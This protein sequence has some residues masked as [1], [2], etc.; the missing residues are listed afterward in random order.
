MDETKPDKR[1]RVYCF[2]D[3]FNLYHAIQWFADGVDDE[4]KRQYRQY[5]WLSLISLAKCYVSSQSQELV[6]VELFTTVTHWDQ[7]KALRHKQF[8]MAQECE[9]VKIT[10][11]HFKE[12]QMLCKATCRAV[13]SDWQEKQTDVNIAVRMVE[14]AHAEAYDKAIIISGD[15]DLIP[16][17][18]LV[19][20]VYKRHVAAVV[21]IGRRGEDIESACDSKF[22]MTEDHLSRSHLPNKLRHPSGQWVLKPYEYA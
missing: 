20:T 21:P 9:G 19:R 12:K 2:V 1:L 5:K 11:G 15:T 16:A 18:Q 17:I 4:Q 10:C 14:L 8:K 7:G 3:G 6:G 13:Y 22:K